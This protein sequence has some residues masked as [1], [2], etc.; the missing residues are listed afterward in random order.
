MDYLHRK[1]AIYFLRKMKAATLYLDL[2]SMRERK[3][4]LIK[5]D[6]WHCHIRKQLYW[7]R[8]TVWWKLGQ[9]LGWGLRRGTRVAGWGVQP[10]F[11]VWIKRRRVDVVLRVC[12]MLGKRLDTFSAV[13][14]DPVQPPC[15]LYYCCADCPGEEFG[16]WRGQMAG[17]R[18]PRSLMAQVDSILS[19]ASS[20]HHSDQWVGVEG[21]ASQTPR[22]S[23]FQPCGA[24]CLL[25]CDTPV[26]ERRLGAGG[27][28]SFP[29]EP[30]LKHGISL[31]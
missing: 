6:S 31:S 16:D 17:L 12:K 9:D 14:I 23:T 30:G 1:E 18:S 4:G 19:P 24:P 22:A 15:P 20:F 8:H 10:G 27:V 11:A 28:A 29:W 3:R 26:T 2:I 13:L 21:N 7:A 25:R 5:C